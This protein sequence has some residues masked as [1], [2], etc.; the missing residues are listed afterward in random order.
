MTKGNYIV[1]TQPTDEP[2]TLAQVKSWL[3]IEHSD[4]DTLLNLLIVAARQDAERYM[5]RAILEQEITETF[6]GF[7]AN[8]FHLSISPL[9]S[10]D[11]ISYLNTA[12]VST[13]LS[14]DFY[15]VDTLAKPPI[16]YR[17]ENAVWPLTATA[18]N[19]V[20]VEYTAG[21]ETAADVPSDMLIGMLLTIADWHDNRT[22]SVRV[23]PT[24]ARVIFDK[25]RIWMF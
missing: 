15:G 5:Q 19:A 14:T 9:V 25:Y 2:L 21:W 10:V 7:G 1:T 22:D 8:G 24:A 4:D 13:L 23:L 11:E 6:S 16:V 17:K 3:R 18:P 12:E 20:T